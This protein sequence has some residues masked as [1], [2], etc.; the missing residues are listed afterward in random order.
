M[1][2]NVP[3]VMMRWAL[4]CVLA[5][6][7][8]PWLVPSNKLYH[9]LIIV[10]LWLP[11]FIALGIGSLRPRLPRVDSLIYLTFVCW[12]LLVLVVR[13]GRSLSVR[14]RWCFMSA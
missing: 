5:M 14:P 10:F 12:T 11:A 1:K 9:Q 13:G 6:L 4:L 8:L 7:C 2:F 3:M